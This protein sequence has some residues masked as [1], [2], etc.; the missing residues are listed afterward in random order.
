MDYLTDEGFAANFGSENI[1]IMN[2]VSW[3]ALANTT[4][5]PACGE[6]ME[7]VLTDKKR[8]FRCMK[9]RCD[10]RELSY[11]VGSVFLKSKLTMREIMGA[12]RCWIKGET[13]GTAIISTGLSPKTLSTWYAAF[14]ELISCDKCNWFSPIGGP[15]IVV[16]V[17]ETLLGRRKN[18]RG[19]YVEGAWVLVGIERTTERRAFCEVVEKRDAE[20]IHSVLRKCVTTGSIVH[21]DEWRGYNGV[22]VACSVTHRTVNHSR[23]FKDPQ[24]GINTNAVEG[25]NGA[26]KRSIPLKFRNNRYAQHYADQFIWKRVNKGNLCHAF[27]E[28]LRNSLLTTK[29]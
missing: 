13:H 24:T 12:A 22:D 3:G 15:G 19:H 8:V 16:Q 17:D 14:R 25:L 29:K 4:E 1:C 6:Q 18:N 9:S 23:F 10:H 2:L 28:V 21:T 26:L 7:L 11:R 5:C 20:T 27:I